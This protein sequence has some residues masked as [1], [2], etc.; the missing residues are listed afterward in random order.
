[1][2]TNGD[3]HGWEW[4]N[5]RVAKK[6]A[7]QQQYNEAKLFWKPSCCEM[8]MERAVNNNNSTTIK[9]KTTNKHSTTES[10]LVLHFAIVHVV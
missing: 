10:T 3:S 6:C 7:Q 9:A 2:E 8:P 5:D 4:Q 1:M